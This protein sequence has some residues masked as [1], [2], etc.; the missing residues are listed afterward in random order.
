MIDLDKYLNQTVDF[1][2]DGKTLHVKQ[3]TALATKQIHKIES[4]I[5][6]QNYL[7]SRCKVTQII[8]NNNEEG[9]NFS[10]EDVEKI[11][12]KV[13]DLIAQKISEM[14]LEVESDPN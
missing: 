6:E 3:P 9:I 4:E 13:Q 5:T 2:L 11:P 14:K 10:I 1:K 7:E 12:Y 8:L